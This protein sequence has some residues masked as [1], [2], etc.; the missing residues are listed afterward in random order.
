MPNQQKGKSIF[1]EDDEGGQSNQNANSETAKKPS[2]V[3][4]QNVAK[5]Q[6]Q[7]KN[8]NTGWFGGI[9]NRLALRPKNQMKLPDDKNPTVSI[10]I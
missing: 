8:E 10:H 9:W 7:D 1:D 3:K 5:G 4:Q 6:P 2:P